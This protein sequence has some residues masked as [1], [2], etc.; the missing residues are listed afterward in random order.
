MK[1][2]SAFFGWLIATATAAIL[3][4]LVAATGVVLGLD[5]R[6]PLVFARDLPLDAGDGRLDRRRARCS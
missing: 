3:T 2:G 5:V 4:G 6:N 1:I